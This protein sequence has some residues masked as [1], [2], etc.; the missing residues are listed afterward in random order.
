MKVHPDEIN[1]PQSSES[2]PHL[3][4]EPQPPGAPLSP[5]PIPECPICFFPYD[6]TFHTPLH[7]PHCTHTFCLHCLS[8]MSLFS[9]PLHGFQC[10][11]CRAP[12]PLPPE[13][14]P[15]LPPNPELVS[16]QGGT[17]RRVWLEGTVL[18]YWRGLEGGMVSSDGVIRLPLTG[19]PT[20]GVVGG[21][22]QPGA[23]VTVLSQH[24]LQGC[25]NVWCLVMLSFLLFVI[26]FI[27]IFLP[28]F[29]P[30]Y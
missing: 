19:A 23:V 10:P 13:G 16:Q 21:G 5:A 8:R 27:A 9:A 22:A 20:G 12:V 18:C 15:C 14:A 6:G 24:R 26:V 1:P 2:T 7:L 25:R 17:L 30:V 3:G 11:L 4:E 28:I 29:L